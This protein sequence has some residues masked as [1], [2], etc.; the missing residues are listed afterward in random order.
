MSAS[1]YRCS[2]MG[3]D[4]PATAVY[5]TKPGTIYGLCDEHPVDLA[6]GDTW[7]HPPA[8]WPV[9]YEATIRVRAIWSDDQV[10]TIVAFINEHA[11]VE[12]IDVKPRDRDAS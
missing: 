9:E 7:V 1:D 5:I 3:C 4:Q 6:P 12:G 8:A 10:D 2:R 11:Y